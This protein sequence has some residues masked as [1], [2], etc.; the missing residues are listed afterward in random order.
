MNEVI[1]RERFRVLCIIPSLPKDLN[2]LTIQS[3]L[4]QTYSVEM[5]VVFPKKVVGKTVSQKVSRVLNEGLSHIK[6]E[7]FDYILRVDCDTIL[8]ADFL[9]ENLKGEPDLCGDAGH[10][11]LIKVKPFLDVMKGK[12]HPLSDDSYTCYKFMKEGCKFVKRRVEPI[13][14]RQMGL[15]HG[16]SYFAKP[17]HQNILYFYNRGKGMHRLG[18]EPF[19]VLGRLRYSIWNVFAVFGY[20]TA[21]IKREKKTDVA[22][23]VWG[24]QVKKLLR[25]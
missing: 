10:A 12:F 5:L 17:G 16:T 7:D 6:L 4:N 14:T 25:L 1:S 2:P 8:P 13:K 20:F 9:E 22:D 11:M 19:H 3:I 18:Y 24:R 21:L 15:H 23:F